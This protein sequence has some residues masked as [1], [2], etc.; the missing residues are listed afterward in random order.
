MKDPHWARG[1]IDRFVLA[2]LEADGL[3]PSPE[4]NR[5]TLIRRL[6]FDLTGLPPTLEGNRR[7]SS[8]QVGSG[9]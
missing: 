2:R 5:E 9:V 3:K 8:R 4:A 1:A 6:S 7:V